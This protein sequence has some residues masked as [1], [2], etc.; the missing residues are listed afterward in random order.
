MG[1]HAQSGATLIPCQ[2]R[3]RDIVCCQSVPAASLADESV[4]TR[5][6]DSCTVP[7][8]LCRRC[9]RRYHRR[10]APHLCC[11]HLHQRRS[12]SRGT[13]WLPCHSLPC[14]LGWCVDSC[15]DLGSCMHAFV[16]DALLDQ[17][18]RRQLNLATRPCPACVL[19]HSQFPSLQRSLQPPQLSPLLL[20]SLQPSSPRQPLCLQWCRPLPSPPLCAP[21]RQCLLWRRRHDLLSRHPPPLPRVLLPPGKLLVCCCYDFWCCCQAPLRSLPPAVV[22]STAHCAL[23]CD[24]RREA[25]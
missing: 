13:C 8:F 6:L 9:C 15:W 20:Q 17:T 21:R 22:P 19:C 16:H 2:A 3:L 23:T 25:P 12:C 18:H 10:C 11:C 5:C 14:C 4:M 1:C 24:G 7:F